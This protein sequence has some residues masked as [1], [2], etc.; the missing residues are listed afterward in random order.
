[1]KV[2]F[3]ASPRGSGLLP[4]FVEFFLKKKYSTVEWVQDR[5]LADMLVFFHMNALEEKMMDQARQRGQHVLAYSGESERNIY[6]L[7]YYQYIGRHR[8]PSMTMNK[9]L[10]QSDPDRH[11][12]I[13]LWVAHYHVYQKYIPDFLLLKKQVEKKD[14]FCCFLARA[15]ERFLLE[16]VVSCYRKV[17]CRDRFLVDLKNLNLQAWKM[18][19]EEQGLDYERMRFPIE[20]I[21]WF[22][23]YRFSI[24]RE[25][26]L[27]PFYNTEKLLDAAI[28]GTVGFY[29][30]SPEI[31]Q[32][33]NP[34]AFVYFRNHFSML[35]TAW[36]IRR[37]HRDPARCQAMLDEPLLNPGVIE[38]RYS[39]GR[40]YQQLHP[41]LP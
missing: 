11:I 10:V 36:Q 13:P 25:N 3:C 31:L 29:S 17:D 38:D 23:L 2:C 28:A 12:L 14:R 30:G 34:R 1:M 19:V 35:S 27:T 37:L 21:L 5:S 26:A 7:N 33:F 22:L 32:D 16:E 39:F 41:L 40:I 20:K 4:Y 6:A 8:I 9:S 24:N 18:K 15:Q